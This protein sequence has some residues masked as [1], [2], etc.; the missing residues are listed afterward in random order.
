MYERPQ[1]WAQTML[2]WLLPG[3]AFLVNWVL[4]GMPTKDPPDPHFNDGCTDY[5]QQVVNPNNL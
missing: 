2:I 4:K 1:Q 5:S 3:S